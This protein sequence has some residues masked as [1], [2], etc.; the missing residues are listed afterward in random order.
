MCRADGVGG[1][2]CG[3]GIREGE[4]GKKSWFISQ[5]KVNKLERFYLHFEGAIGAWIMPK[6]EMEE[7]EES[8]KRND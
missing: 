3:A 5:I 1:K 6:W 8:E 4:R 7:E 2:F